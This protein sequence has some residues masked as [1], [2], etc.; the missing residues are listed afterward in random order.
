MVTTRIKFDPASPDIILITY[1]PGGFGNFVYHLLTEF[2]DQTAKPNNTQFALSSSGNSHSTKKYTVT[3]L[4]SPA[5]YHPYIDADVVTDNKKILVL[6]DNEWADNQYT[7]LR[8][9]FPNASIVRMCSQSDIYPIVCA[10]VTAK[11]Q[12][13]SANLYCPPDYPGMGKFTPLE[14]PGVINVS[15]Q[16]FILDPFETF[17]KLTQE[18]GLTVINTEQLHTLVAEWRSIHRPYFEDLY[19][20]F[21]KEHLL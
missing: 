5:K 7:Q 13:I 6:V 11:T 9:D 15:I 12:G 19:K 8:K 1:P 4:H 16:D 3:Y 14:M 18:L 17:Y 21:H 10:L 2:T 20:E